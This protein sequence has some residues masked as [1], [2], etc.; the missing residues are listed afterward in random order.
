MPPRL[1]SRRRK[2]KKHRA[3]ASEFDY[4][5]WKAFGEWR[6]NEE[7]I[8]NI[9]FTDS[10][11]FCDAADNDCVSSP[12]RTPRRPPK[13]SRNCWNRC[14]FPSECRWGSQYGMQACATPILPPSPEEHPSYSDLPILEPQ[15]TRPAAP[16]LDTAPTTRSS[17]TYTPPTTFD[18]IIDRHQEGELSPLSPKELRERFWDGI[19]DSARQRKK[20]KDSMVHSPLALNPVLEKSEHE[21]PCLTAPEPTF[22]DGGKGSR[23]GQT[24]VS[25]KLFEALDRW[26]LP[27]LGEEK[28]VQAPEPVIVV[29]SSSATGHGF[30]FGFAEDE[31]WDAEIRRTESD[32]RSEVKE[33]RGKGKLRKKC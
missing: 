31:I 30:D 11:D 15:Q 24:G 23:S 14:D 6:R 28:A 7:T 4:A 16:T 19:L 2:T 32:A 10:V 27:G 18:G 29:A 21:S 33:R 1:S 13:S 3:C 5:G 20:S 8:R 25:E 12:F 22:D 26:T 9:S 17:S